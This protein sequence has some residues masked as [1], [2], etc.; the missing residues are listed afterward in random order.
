[1]AIC[2]PW[3]TALK[4]NPRLSAV[5]VLAQVITPKG[6][7]ISLRHA[8]EK[9]REQL[10]SAQEKGLFTDI[11]YGVCRHYD[12]LNHWLGEQLEKPIKPSAWAVKMALL[13]GIYELW[14][15]SRPAH[16]VVNQYPDVCRQLKAKWA[17]GLCNAVLRKAAR[18]DVETWRE[19]QIPQI[20][21]SVPGWLWQQWRR[22]WGEAAALKI[23]QA[24]SEQAPLTLRFNPQHHSQASALAA[25]ESSGIQVRAGELSAQAIY[26][27]EACP[28]SQIP[29][30]NDGHFSVQDEAAQLASSLIEA[31]EQGRILDAC[32]APGGKTGHLAERFPQAHITALDSEESRLERIHQNLSRLR[33]QATVICGDASQPEQWHS[34][35][36]Y[37]AILIDA[38][39]SATGILRRQP[40]VKWHRR[41]QDIEALVVLQRQIL[42]ALWPLLAPGGTLVYATCS[43]LQQENQEQIQWFL[44]QHTEAQEDTPKALN[45]AQAAVGAQL[46]PQQQGTDGFYLARLRKTQS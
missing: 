11:S 2:L 27:D 6:T 37:D 17:V 30:F 22:Q 14:F 40:D 34:G 28:I 16:A 15:S 9:P 38:P 41:P 5:R 10:Q 39:C 13:A 3:E 45:K 21:Y 33:A 26:L 7:G 29:G 4:T 36:M 19:Q 20:N 23:A 25:L 44:D 42:T 32:A 18:F 1:M 43:I 8:I 12:L 31:P 46:L 24:S 35:G